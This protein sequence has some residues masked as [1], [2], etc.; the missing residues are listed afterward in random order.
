[1]YKQIFFSFFYE[2][3]YHSKKNSSR[4]EYTQ[5]VQKSWTN[6]IIVNNKRVRNTVFYRLKEYRQCLKC[7]QNKLEESEASNSDNIQL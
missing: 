6:V 3:S 5:T 4:V 2:Y 7:E 1:M